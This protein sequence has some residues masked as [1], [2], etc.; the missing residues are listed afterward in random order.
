MDLL[1]ML[2]NLCLSVKTEELLTAK[3]N[4]TSVSEHVIL[5]SNIFSVLFERI[6]KQQRALS[7]YDQFYGSPTHD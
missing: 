6:V 4:L 1:K 5:T 7:K 3:T 2:H